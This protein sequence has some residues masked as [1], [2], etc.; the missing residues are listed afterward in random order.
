MSFISFSEYLKTWRGHGLTDQQAAE[1]LLLALRDRANARHIKGF[2]IERE[3]IAPTLDEE[4]QSW[5]ASKR[6]DRIARWLDSAMAWRTRKRLAMLQ[7]WVSTRSQPLSPKRWGLLLFAAYSLERDLD[8]YRE[9]GKP[10]ARSRPISA[11]R[12]AVLERAGRRLR[13]IA[14]PEDQ[15]A[16]TFIDAPEP[17]PADFW[18]A[19]DS[20]D[21]ALQSY[22]CNDDDEPEAGISVDWRAG[23]LTEWDCG[24]IVEYC[25]LEV[26]YSL[27]RP[28]IEEV[29]DRIRKSPITDQ[30]KFR[31]ANAAF[32]KASGIKSGDEFREFWVKVKYSEKRETRPGRPPKRIGQKVP[33]VEL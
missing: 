15:Y 32:L 10:E 6:A 25:N 18:A 30:A 26:H 29:A 17:V 33:A 20:V 1:R 28:T 2:R 11:R 3:Q 19:L 5:R 31:T 4:R 9:R 12:R 14:Q 7:K 13:A 23:K 16:E 8:E 24:W 22:W 27:T 21:S